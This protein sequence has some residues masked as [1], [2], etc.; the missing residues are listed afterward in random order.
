MIKLAKR[1]DSNRFHLGRLSYFNMSM[2]PFKRLPNAEIS[3]GCDLLK[4]SL[5][6]RINETR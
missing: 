5:Y 3:G 6:R 2:L 1:F 4:I